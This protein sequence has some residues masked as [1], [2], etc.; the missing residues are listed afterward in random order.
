MRRANTTEYKFV[1]KRK[2][3]L[4][5]YDDI[6]ENDVY[7]RLQFLQTIDEIIVGNITSGSMESVI[8][9]AATA[10]YVDNSE[11]FDDDEFPSNDELL[12]DLAVMEYVAE[13]WRD[14]AKEDEWAEKISSSIKSL[15]GEDPEDLQNKLVEKSKSDA[16]YGSISFRAKISTFDEKTAS[17]SI[18]ALPSNVLLVFDSTGLR[19]LSGEVGASKTTLAKFGYADIERWGGTRNKFSLLLHDSTIDSKFSLLVTRCNGTAISNYLLEI[20]E[21]IMEVS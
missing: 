10:V 19:F 1:Y 9:T 2:I 21:A 20:I 3:F 5:Q 13:S 15:V 17:P 8:E 7:N 18:K 11:D 4:K 16:M 12:D 14:S 6:S